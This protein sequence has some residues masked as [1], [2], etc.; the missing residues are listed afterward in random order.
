MDERRNSDGR[1]AA[2]APSDGVTLKT[3]KPIAST[4]DLDEFVQDLLVTDKIILYHL[5]K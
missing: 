2:I 1:K 3:A 5:A 4:P